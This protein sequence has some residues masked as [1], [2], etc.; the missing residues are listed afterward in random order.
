[1]RH[2]TVSIKDESDRLLPPDW[3]RKATPSGTHYYVN[4]KSV[5]T[6]WSSPILTTRVDPYDHRHRRV[7]QGWER[8]YTTNKRCYY[9]NAA[10]RRRIWGSRLHERRDAASAAE[11]INHIFG[12]PTAEFY[13]RAT[14]WITLLGYAPLILSRG[15]NAIDACYVVHK[16][17]SRGLEHGFL[18]DWIMLWDIKSGGELWCRGADSAL[19]SVPG[20]DVHVSEYPRDLLEMGRMRL[21]FTYADSIAKAPRI[22]QTDRRF[23]GNASLMAQLSV[24]FSVDPGAFA[25]VLRLCDGKSEPCWVPPPLFNLGYSVNETF[26]LRSGDCQYVGFKAFSEHPYSRADRR[27]FRKYIESH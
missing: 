5:L 2:T 25:T 26:T 12:V 9:V 14:E 11:E 3:V 16:L 17:T 23:Y 15:R 19:K 4:T 6:S 10:T 8:Q 22:E 27:S 13:P 20:P 18:F 24:L 21:A 7:P 1:M